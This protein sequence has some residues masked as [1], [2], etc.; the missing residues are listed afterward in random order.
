M[1]NSEERSLPKQGEEYVLVHNHIAEVIVSCCPNP[2][3]G[4]SEENHIE[5]FKSANKIM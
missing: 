5:Y 1:S 3:N 2:K 4:E